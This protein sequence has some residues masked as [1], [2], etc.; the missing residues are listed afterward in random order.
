MDTSLTAADHLEAA[1]NRVLEEQGSIQ[2]VG[3]PLTPHEEERLKALEAACEDIDSALS[4][5][6]KS[7]MK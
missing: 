6:K 4:Q 5:L 3:R 1:K 2:I 7:E